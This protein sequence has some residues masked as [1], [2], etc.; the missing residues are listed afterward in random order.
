LKKAGYKVKTHIIFGDL[1]VDLYLPKFRLAIEVDGAYHN[2]EDQKKQDRKKSY[3]LK[4]YYRLNVR[5]FKAK[6]AI[7]K[8][9]WCVEKVHEWTG[10]PRKSLWKWIMRLFRKHR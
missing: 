10:G 3:V 5:Q 2:S 9:D 6:Q 4:R 7:Q 8:T 1:E